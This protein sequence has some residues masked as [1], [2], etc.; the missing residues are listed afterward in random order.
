MVNINNIRCLYK[1]YWIA[2]ELINLHCLRKGNISI[3]WWRRYR[4]LTRIRILH[5]KYF[6][7][8]KLIVFQL[9]VFIRQRIV[10]TKIIIIK[11]IPVFHENL[12]IYVGNF[13]FKNRLLRLFRI[14]SSH[15]NQSFIL[16]KFIFWFFIFF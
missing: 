15:F 11:V 14:I 2:F 9:L 4:L 5:R 10:F 3:H 12:A 8:K 13:I 1:G 6:L 7:V 16:F